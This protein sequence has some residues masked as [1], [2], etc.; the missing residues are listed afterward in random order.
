MAA[1][2]YC[3]VLSGQWKTVLSLYNMS[4]P[5]PQYWKN[6]RPPKTSGWNLLDVIG[7]LVAEQMMH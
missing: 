4:E 6:T 7:H 1:F 2:L 3:I 5:G